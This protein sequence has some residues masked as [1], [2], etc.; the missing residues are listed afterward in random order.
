[1]QTHRPSHARRPRPLR[2]TSL[3]EMLVV[4]S[5]LGI[6]SALA[7]PN[8]AP[9]AASYRLHAQTAELAAVIDQAR[10][11]AVSEGRCY[12][13]RLSG[14]SIV[15]EGRNSSDCVN[16][17]L[18]GW[19]TRSAIMGRD[20]T[21]VFTVQSLTDASGVTAADHRIVFRPNGTLWGDGDLT[22]TDDG[23]RI[24][25]TNTSAP[26]QRAVIIQATGR[27]CTRNHN[28]SAPVITATGA[29]DC[30]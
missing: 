12:R 24:L 19:N 26:E 14:G 22:V 16:L 13:V 7:V 15:V 25:L 23:A 18:D 20:G 10:R 29:L 9:T 27:V 3:I 1:M 21:T 5:L 2:G 28:G 30:L 17:N 6:I 4:V 11:R 8:I